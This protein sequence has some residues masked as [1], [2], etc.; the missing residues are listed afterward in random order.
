M[1]TQTETRRAGG[2]AGLADC[3]RRLASDNR[4]SP[5]KSVLNQEQSRARLR[6]QRHVECLHRLGP[7]P[8]FH[9]LTDLD[10]GK[11]LWPAVEEYAA[12]P[13]DYFIKVLGGDQFA[14]L[15]HVIDEG[16]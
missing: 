11:P 8:L 5:P 3:H 12:L 2:A 1:G 9:P 14:P 4:V 15:V 16:G 10:A 6:R 13:A 7:A